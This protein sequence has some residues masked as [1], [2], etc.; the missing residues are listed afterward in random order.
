MARKISMLQKPSPPVACAPLA[1]LSP[2]GEGSGRL[3]NRL[4]IAWRE[5]V[6]KAQGWN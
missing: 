3:R 6:L 4:V 5:A 2:Q 1:T